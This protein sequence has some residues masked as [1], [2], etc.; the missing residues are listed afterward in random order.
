[1]TR[2]P[3]FLIAVLAVF[4]A[5]GPAAEQ[6]FLP[7]LPALQVDFGVR[8][9]IAQLTISLALLTMALAPLAC[10]P[11]SDRVGSVRHG[12]DTSI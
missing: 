11:W 7:A 10:G 5:A 8:I 3:R 9:T 2:P 6:V 4:V 1:M 12:D